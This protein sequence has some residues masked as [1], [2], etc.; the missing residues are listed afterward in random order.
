MTDFATTYRTHTCGDLTPDKAGQSVTVSGFVDRRGE[1]SIGL[2]DRYGSAKLLLGRDAQPAVKKQ[3]ETL[4]P[5]SVIQVSGKLVAR[6]KAK[7]GEQDAVDLHVEKLTL[8]AA[9]EAL[10][11]ELSSEEIS[12]DDR[13]RY[14]NLDLR[15]QPMQ[16]RL[17][18]RSRFL[19]EVRTAL[20]GQGFT[21]IETPLLT[22][23]TP[24]ATQSFVVP[25]SAGRAFALPGTPQPY[26]QLLMAGGVDRYFQLARCFRNE[27]ELTGEKQLEFTTLDVEMAFADEEDIYKTVDAVLSHVWSACVGS[28]IATPIPRLT[29]TEAMLK[30]GTDCPDLRFAL[31][32]QDLTL[33]ASQ[34]VSA[35]FRDNAGCRAIRAEA[36]ADVIGDNELN[37]LTSKLTKPNGATVSWFKVGPNRHLRGPATKL[38][39]ANDH[40]D[41]LQSHLPAQPGDVVVLIIT[42]SRDAANKPAGAARKALGKALAATATSDKPAFV[43][44]TRFPFFEYNSDDEAWVACRHPFTQPVAEDA[45]YVETDKTKVRTKAYDIVMNGVE[46]GAGSIRN[47]DVALQRKIFE[48]FEYKPAEV[49][50][51]FGAILDAFRFGVPPH[52]GFAIGVD[53]LLAM[54]QGVDDIADVIAFPKNRAGEDPLFSAPSTIDPEVLSSMLGAG[55]GV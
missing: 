32:I 21:E 12:L 42:K 15:R 23:W 26:K 2:R 10:P 8:L 3:W 22:K 53:R 40:H 16:D 28:S 6:P 4:Q 7:P 24:E 43:I 36:A 5:E 13:L 46:L 39:Q 44:V 55:V 20:H 31:E 52:G 9:S 11:P 48:M 29:Y 38:F 41:L 18:F 25:A 50:A 34:A 35:H 1:G 30:Y 49:E 54:V 27:Q 14:R 47:H 17:A 33:F 51:R 19:H 37:Q 45:Q